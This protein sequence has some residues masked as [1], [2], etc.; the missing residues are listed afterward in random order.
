MRTSVTGYARANTDR[1]RAR[2]SGSVAVTWWTA[3]QQGDW[4]ATTRT[5]PVTLTDR[6]LGGGLPAGTRGVVVERRG[7]RLGV[8]LDGGWGRVT[9]EVHARD[10]RL[11]GRGR[12]AAAFRSRTS[13]LAAARIAVAGM[14]LLPVG[15][16]VL[17]YLWAYH[18]FDGILGAFAVAVL[19]GAGQSLIAALHEPVRALVYFVVV[20]VLWRIAFGYRSRPLS[21]CARRR[22]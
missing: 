10:L 5:V 21:R 19:D 12:G 18:T 8:E 7:G 11:V 15:H 4:V 2:T 1:P 16:F 3:P 6:A 9:A 17:A 13:R 22:S 20:A 14:L